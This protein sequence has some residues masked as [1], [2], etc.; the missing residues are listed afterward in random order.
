MRI[1]VKFDTSIFRHGMLALAKQ[2]PFAVATAMNRSAEEGQQ[3]VKNR[4]LMRGFKIRSAASATWLTN[5][6]KIYR[7]E[8]ATKDSL[9]VTIRMGGGAGA[10]NVD[11]GSA[12]GKSL[13]SFL[14]A[15]GERLGARPIGSGATFGP[16]VVIPVLTGN[17]IMPRALYPIALGLAPRRQIAGGFT[18]AALQGKRRTFVVSM[19]DGTG[20]VLQRTGP[21]K[22]DVRVLFLIRKSEHVS[23]RYFFFEVAPKVFA[24]RFPINLAGM[25][26]TALRTAR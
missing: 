25:Y 16:S 26:Q 17:E 13:L 15:G 1:D 12:R 18:K 10:G 5:Q 9:T 22:H 3:A 6:V 23:G 19:G 21:G 20:L 11:S 14:E 7:G 24:E 8:R 4:I 2:L